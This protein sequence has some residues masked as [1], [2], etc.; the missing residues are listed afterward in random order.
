MKLR[1]RV[2]ECLAVLAC[3]LCAGCV[4]HKSVTA[5]GG[6]YEEVTHPHHNFNFDSEPPPPRVSLQ[7]R[8]TDDQ[9]K[10]IW[11]ALYGS[12]TIMNSNVVIFVAEKANLADHTT[13]PRLFAVRSTDIPLDITDAV[14]WHWAR[15]NGKDVR[16]TIDRCAEVQPSQEENGLKVHIDF[17][18]R[19]NYAIRDDWPDDGSIQLTWKQIDQII[20]AVKAKGVLQKDDRWGTPYMS[21][22]L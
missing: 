11:P 9:I 8:G 17:W 20:Y 7:Y 12:T 6:G 2:I 13:H 10:E 16:K 19:E 15:A 4:T 14:L 21:G 18:P 1:K 22:T 5:I 3:I